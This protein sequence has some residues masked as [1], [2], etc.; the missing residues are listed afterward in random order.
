MLKYRR[1]VTSQPLALLNS[2]HSASRGV[3]LHDPAVGVHHDD[4]RVDALDNVLEFFLLLNDLAIHLRARDHR[5]KVMRHARKQ[6]H[7][8][9]YENI[10]EALVEDPKNTDH[11]TL[12]N[13]V[14]VLVALL[15][16]QRHAHAVGYLQQGYIL[17]KGAG[18][19]YCIVE[20]NRLLLTEDLAGNSLT[21]RYAERF[22]FGIGEVQ[23]G[24][25]GDQITIV[26]IIEHENAFLALE[27]HARAHHKA[28]D[29]L[30][31]LA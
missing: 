29:H 16:D 15:D 21:G 20:D 2:E 9:L 8:F 17:A 18:V 24:L 25:G 4:A 7:V 31:E 28:L 14:R 19:T 22:D 10:A 3:H 23:S 26:L 13:L 11:S 5:G 30:L 1:V 27:E 6:V 12:K